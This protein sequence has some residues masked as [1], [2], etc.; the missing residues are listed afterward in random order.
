MNTK[1]QYMKESN[2]LAGNATN[3]F[4]K[5]CKWMNTRGGHNDLKSEIQYVPSEKIVC[6]I[7]RKDI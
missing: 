4:L 2:I 3:N 1:G 6:Y 5:Q 7:A